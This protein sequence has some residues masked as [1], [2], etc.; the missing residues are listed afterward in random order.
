MA[1]MT[2]KAITAIL[3]NEGLTPEEKTEQ[4]FSLHGQAL[5]AGY[6]KILRMKLPSE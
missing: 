6:V 1:Y 4:I 3:A 5:D 2:R